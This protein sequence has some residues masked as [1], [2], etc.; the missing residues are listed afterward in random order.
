ML[1]QANYQHHRSFLRLSMMIRLIRD[2]YLSCNTGETQDRFSGLV[3]HCFSGDGF[4]I[5][6]LDL[7]NFWT[8]HL[9]KRIASTWPRLSR[10][11]STF[12]PT[13]KLDG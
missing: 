7:E 10:W 4:L 5:L 13:L 1:A 8:H 2:L 12:T 3:F 6:V 11:Y 9:V